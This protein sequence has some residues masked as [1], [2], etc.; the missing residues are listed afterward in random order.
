MLEERNV[1]KGQLLSIDAHSDNGLPI[2]SAHYAA[3]L[4]DDGPMKLCFFGRAGITDSWDKICRTACD[5]ARGKDIISMT[6]SC[7]AGGTS[8]F[9]V[10]YNAEITRDQDKIEYAECSADSWNAAAQGLIKMLSSK[11]VKEGQVI[12]IDA[13]NNG[14]NEAAMFAAFFCRTWPAKGNLNLVFW[15]QND[16]IPWEKI[17]EGVTKSVE[18]VQK[19]QLLGITGS[20]NMHRRV[21]YAFWQVSAQ[22]STI[23]YVE[24]RASSWNGAADGLIKKLKEAGVRQGQV[25]SIDA[26]NSG[27]NELA[28]FSAHYLKSLEDRGQLD[29]G[30][31]AQNSS[32]GWETFYTEASKHAE[33]KDVISMTGSINTS[34]RSIFYVFFNKGT[35]DAGVENVEHVESRAG[36]WN[37]AADG[38]IKKL[39]ENEVQSGGGPPQLDLPEPSSQVCFVAPST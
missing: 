35:E 26:H 10:F 32:S 20:C 30:Y 31:T 24:S 34:D 6:G 28:I 4:R 5:E 23:Q 3:D 39:R 1:R 11:G 33:G 14:P 25:L 2:I 37:G 18:A 12:N 22:T 8:A 36:S 38:I 19:E 29:I 21:M 9:Y 16:D 7:E 27:E 15:H 17:Y 13:H